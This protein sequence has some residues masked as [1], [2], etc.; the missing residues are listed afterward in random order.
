VP[1]GAS[2]TEVPDPEHLSIDEQRLASGLRALD[3]V[4]YLAVRCFIL[5]RDPRLA[6]AIYD[7]IFLGLRPR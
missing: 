3:N 6:Q 2:R 7:A 4:Q 5:R 1:G